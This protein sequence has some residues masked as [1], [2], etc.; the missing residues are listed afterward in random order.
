MLQ[1]SQKILSLALNDQLERYFEG[2]TNSVLPKDFKFDSNSDEMKNLLQKASVCALGLSSMSNMNL[3]PSQLQPILNFV[4]TNKNPKH[5]PNN[6]RFPFKPMTLERDSFFP[7]MEDGNYSTLSNSFIEEYQRLPN[8]NL[9]VHTDTLY[10]LL[11]KYASCISVH[12]EV[13]YVSA[14]DFLKTRAALAT[15]FANSSQN[16]LQPCLLVCADLSGIQSYLYD[17]TRNKAAKSLKGRS[18]YL[19]LLLD[20]ISHLILSHPDIQLGVA[21]ILYCSGGKMYLLLPNTDKVKSALDSLDTQIQA[22]LFETHKTRLYVCFDYLEFGFTPDGNIDK[23][24]TVADLWSQLRKRT[25][26]KKLLPF[27]KL[28]NESFSDFFEP[29]DEGFAENASIRKICS[30]TGDIILN[31]EEEKNNLN[32]LS[33]EKEPIWVSQLEFQ[34]AEI[35]HDLMEITYYNTH[36]GN[37]NL[38]L[39]HRYYCDQ[40]LKLPVFHELKDDKDFEDEYIKIKGTLPSL[41]NA[42]LRKIND[43]NFLP[44]G[45]IKG[46]NSSYGFSLYGGNQQAYLHDEHGIPK[47]HNSRKVAKDFDQLCGIEEES[48]RGKGFNKLGVLRMDVDNLGSLFLEGL[49]EFNSLSAYSTLSGQLDWFF[50]GYLNTLRN[51]R[52]VR[53]GNQDLHFASHLNILYSGGDDLFIIGRW[54]MAIEFAE[55]IRTEFRDFVCGRKDLSISGGLVMV[56]GKFPISKAAELSGKAEKNA[57]DYAGKNA[58]SIFGETLGWNIEFEKVKSLKIQLINFINKNTFS[59]GFLQRLI[60]FQTI[61]NAHLYGSLQKNKPDKSYRWKTAW[62]FAKILERNTLDNEAKSFLNKALTEHFTQDRCYDLYATAARWAE[63]ELR[64]SDNF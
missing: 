35:G 37:R 62:Y 14:F 36:D 10:F 8:A 25:A 60:D 16:N 44:S 38:S 1:I 22:Q 18:F 28:L 51:T 21:N 19:Q 41:N 20:S 26:R 46:I 55:L 40:P 3:K 24:R 2:F 63:L 30:I 56:G 45:I 64:T 5:T 11:K 7:D 53:I 47:R 13:P 12:P 50:S 54:D 57:K 23:N 17:I 39:H 6:S 42:L 9:K 43:T 27:K 15:C 59:R 49:N 58:I 48:R 33:N 29:I 31:P 61:K 52:S 34:Q 4:K 32:R